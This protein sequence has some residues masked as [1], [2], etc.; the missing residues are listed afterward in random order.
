[1]SARSIRSK[2]SSREILG[3]D[4]LAVQP[5]NYLQAMK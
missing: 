5:P 4:V 3:L 2:V 1:L